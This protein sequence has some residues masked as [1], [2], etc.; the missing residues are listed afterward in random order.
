MTPSSINDQGEVVGYMT[1][2]R[3]SVEGFLLQ[4]GSFAE[5]SYPRS[6]ETKALGTNKQG[7]IVGSYVDAS[8]R[9]HGFLLRDAQSNPR[10]QSV[11]AAKA[12]GLTVLTGINAHGDLV[13]YY[14]N[15]SSHIRALLRSVPQLAPPG[16]P[17]VIPVWGTA[18]PTRAL[19]RTNIF[20]PS[21][22]MAAARIRASRSRK[23][24]RASAAVRP[25]NRTS[26]LVS[27]TT[28]AVTPSRWRHISS[29]TAT[30]KT[31]SLHVYPNGITP[32]NRYVQTPNPSGPDCKPDNANASMRMNLGDP[33]LNAWLYK[34][35]WT[36]TNYK[37]DFP[38]PYG[39]M[40]DTLSV[41]AYSSRRRRPGHA[42]STE[43]GSGIKPSGFANQIGNSPYHA[44][45]D[46]ESAIGTF[47]NGACGGATCLNMAFNGVAGGGLGT[48]ARAATLAAAIAMAWVAGA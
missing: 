25:A 3:G 10:W 22:S 31:G 38:P 35:V 2:S 5:F 32:S 33:A 46:F 16:V 8:G 43:Y 26:T 18:H 27:L 36:G 24:A 34:N 23:T 4:G 47:I 44:A 48:S 13:G 20:M 21:S 12:D 40:E 41:F 29:P 7:E 6:V 17:L 42:V 28:S 45:T 37:N 15:K 11:D 39:V 30:M 19:S 14:R 9:T 1:T